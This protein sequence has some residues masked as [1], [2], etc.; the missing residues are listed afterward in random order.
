MRHVLVMPLD[1]LLCRGQRTAPCCLRDY[2]RGRKDY[3]ITLKRGGNGKEFDDIIPR[4]TENVL[5]CS[6]PGRYSRL[7]TIFDEFGEH[8]Q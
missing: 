5:A 8:Q 4:V 2:F 3:R 1:D 7:A 6:H